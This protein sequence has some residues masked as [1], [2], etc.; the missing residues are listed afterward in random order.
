MSVS[1]KT[2]APHFVRRFLPQVFLWRVSNATTH[3]HSEYM[4][5]VLAFQNAI[6]KDQFISE[7]ARFIQSPAFAMMVITSSESKVANV[8]DSIKGG[9]RVIAE[10]FVNDP[11]AIVNDVLLL[12]DRRWQRRPELMLWELVLAF[13]LELLVWLV[14]FCLAFHRLP[15][16]LRI[17]TAGTFLRLL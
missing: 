4:H 10:P 6:L 5:V 7:N 14:S 11:A 17:R 2:V 3:S 15:R 12:I 1:I 16:R 8:P 13:V 9:D